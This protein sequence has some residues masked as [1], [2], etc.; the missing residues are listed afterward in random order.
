MGKKRLENIVPTALD[1][2]SISAMAICILCKR[3]NF[4]IKIAKL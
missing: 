4:V 3:K 2:S 1:P